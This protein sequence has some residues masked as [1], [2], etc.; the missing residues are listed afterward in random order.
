MAC[1]SCVNKMKVHLASTTQK[2]NLL[3]T[4]PDGDAFP[5]TTT[6]ILLVPVDGFCP[7]NVTIL[8]FWA[9]A[10]ENVP[11]FCSCVG[12]GALSTEVPAMTGICAGF[13]SVA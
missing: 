4:R 6:G 1:E 8:E 7:G 12:G 2:Q 10:G 5:E 9:I 3:S 11:N 13:S